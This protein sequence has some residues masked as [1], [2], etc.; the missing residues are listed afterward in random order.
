MDLA[1]LLGVMCAAFSIC[2]SPQTPAAVQ[3]AVKVRMYLCAP[4]VGQYL[5]AAYPHV[6]PAE[7]SFA[8]LGCTR[9]PWIS[10]YEKSRSHDVAGFY[11][12]AQADLF[13]L[14]VPNDQAAVTASN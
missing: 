13:F 8:V 6:L 3:T 9:L 14:A 1:S 7:H 2:I 12:S 4:P 5:A 10:L 11:P